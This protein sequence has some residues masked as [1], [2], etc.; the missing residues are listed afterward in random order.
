MA[1]ILDYLESSNDKKRK[2]IKTQKQQK[3]LVFNKYQE[4]INDLEELLELTKDEKIYEM[5]KKVKKKQEKYYISGLVS[6][7][8]TINIKKVKKC[9]KYEK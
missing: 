8:K 5:L 6:Q 2:K 7:S 3:I 4:V 1:S 9:E